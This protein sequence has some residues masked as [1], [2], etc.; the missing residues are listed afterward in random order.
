MASFQ[1]TVITPERNVLE[2]DATFAAFPAHDGEMG[3]LPRRAPLVCKLGIGVLRVEAADPSHDRPEAAGGRHVLFIDGG[4]AQVVHN[5]LT[6]LTEQAREPKGIDAAAAEKALV[7]ARAMK[8]TDDASYTARD[9]AIQRA[10]VQLS[11]A[12]PGT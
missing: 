9:K 10:K 1:C 12:R 11:L 6:I 8:I 4:F 3:I 5:R 7:G 2:C